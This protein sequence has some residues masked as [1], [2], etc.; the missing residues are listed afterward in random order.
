MPYSVLKM[1]TMLSSKALRCLW[2]F[3][4]MVAGLNGTNDSDRTQTPNVVQQNLELS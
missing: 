3:L 1:L 2:D 4:A